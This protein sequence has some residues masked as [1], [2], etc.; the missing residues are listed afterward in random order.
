MKVLF[1]G[2]II[3]FT[4]ACAIADVTYDE[5]YGSTVGRYDIERSPLQ[6]SAPP[7][8]FD[9]PS[10]SPAPFDDANAQRFRVYVKG[11]KMARI[12]TLTS[13]IYDLDAGTV[14]LIDHENSTYTVLSVAAMER[15]IEKRGGPTSGGKLGIVDTGRTMQIDGETATEHLVTLWNG[16]TEDSPAIAHATY[17]IAQK[18][19]SEELAAFQKRCLTKYGHQYPAVCSLAESSGF[20]I[21]DKDTAGIEGYPVLKIVESRMA[22]PGPLD[23]NTSSAEIYPADRSNPTNSHPNTRAWRNSPPP[24][25]ARILRTEVRISNFVDGPVDDSYFA[26]PK[27]YKHKKSWFRY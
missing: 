21:L 5:S 11:N 1:I 4:T 6:I 22:I 3:G 16:A 20:G 23:E 25:F 12:G 14:T 27:R 7:T 15:R 24:S 10:Y 26:I 19:P 18:L 17:W 9:S 2:L 13:T 8:V